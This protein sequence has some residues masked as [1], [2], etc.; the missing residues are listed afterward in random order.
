MNVASHLKENNYTSIRSDES[1]NKY[2]KSDHFVKSEK[3][4]QYVSKAAGDHNVT[5][6][7]W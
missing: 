3:K 2:K 6:L 7:N 4:F 5:V 1:L